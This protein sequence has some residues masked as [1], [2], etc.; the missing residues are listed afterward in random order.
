VFDNQETDQGTLFCR[1]HVQ[2]APIRSLA[3]SCRLF[4][5][6]M[7]T[8]SRIKAVFSYKV[9]RERRA[10]VTNRWSPSRLIHTEAHECGPEQKRE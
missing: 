9:S 5:V 2:T 10:E 4:T 1:S 7:L 3:E 8:C 6:L